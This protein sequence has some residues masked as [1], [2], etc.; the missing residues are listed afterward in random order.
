MRFVISTLISHYSKVKVPPREKDVKHTV[1]RASRASRTKGPWTTEDR[2]PIRLNRKRQ[3]RASRAIRR[4]GPP[5]LRRA[6]SFSPLR[7]VVR[8][9]V[10]LCR[11][12]PFEN[13]TVKDGTV[14]ALPDMAL[15]GGP[16]PRPLAM[17]VRA[18]PYQTRGY[19]RGGDTAPQ[20]RSSGCREL[21]FG[22]D[23]PCA[24]LER[25][26]KPFANRNG[27]EACCA[28]PCAKEV[29]RRYPRELS[30]HPQQ[31]C[32]PRALVPLSLPP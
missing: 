19:D 16:V 21:V 10:S 25:T 15:P 32:P 13:R 23:A 12:G 22:R 11:P 17:M 5:A 24:A 8:R 20:K 7:A 18:L 28:P 14:K 29:S 27:G 4:R 26:V 2:R 31:P 9:P 30:H 6:R 3:D 1:P